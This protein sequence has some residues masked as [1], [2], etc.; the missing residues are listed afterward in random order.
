VTLS[1]SRA[2]LLAL[3]VALATAVL[4]A[5]VPATP[6]SASSSTHRQRASK[7]HS[8]RHHAKKRTKRVTRK[9]AAKKKATAKKVTVTVAA[10]ARPADTTA[11]FEDQVTIL[12]NNERAQHGC[13]PVHTD[14]RLRAA[15][16]AYS[17]D[18]ATRGYFS[19]TGADGSIFTQRDSRAGYPSAIGENIAWGQATPG[20]V[21]Y[22]WMNSEGHRANILN[23]Q[24]AA[25]GVGLGWA[26][27]GTPYWT[28]EFGAY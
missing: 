24:A 14:E 20:D 15:A 5:V 7:S 12:V 8:A 2:A 16:R 26:A 28:Q 3:T 6:A 21:M 1:R 23:C 18:M 25:L 11:Y 22:A 19:H 27:N 10:P 9:A 4:A 13:G 17:V